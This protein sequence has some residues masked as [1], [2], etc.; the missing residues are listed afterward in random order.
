MGNALP[1]IELGTGLEVASLSA[2]DS[3]TCA[4]MTNG[5]VKCWGENQ[6]GQLGQGNTNSIG[7]A[8]GT[9]GDALSAVDF[10]GP[11]VVSLS[12]GNFHNCALLSDGTTKCWGYNQ[13]GQ[14][15][16]GDTTNRGDMPG[17]MGSSLP[18]TSY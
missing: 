11:T 1:T 18:V 15:G 3:S 5:S 4:L 6:Y 13:F 16:L 9:M 7:L 10:G 8:D 17:E 14:L 2:A 12:S